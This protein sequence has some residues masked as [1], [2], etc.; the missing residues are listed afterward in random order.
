[1]SL[2]SIYFNANA[3]RLNRTATKLTVVGTVF[4]TWTLITGFFGQNF[5]WLVSNVSTRSDFLIFG[6]GGLLVPT[7]ALGTL[8]WVKRR[9]WF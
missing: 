9:D 4:V 1:M 3:D 8:F 6:L 5:G 7:A 2:A